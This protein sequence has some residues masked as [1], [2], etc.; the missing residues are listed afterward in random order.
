MAIDLNDYPNKIS[1]LGKIK[2]TG[3]WEHYELSKFYYRFKINGTSYKRIIDFSDKAWDKKTINKQLLSEMEKLKNDPNIYKKIS[4]NY[5]EPKYKST[6]TLNKVIDNY[7]KSKEKNTIDNKIIYDTTWTETKKRHYDNYIRKQIG[8]YK[9]SEIKVSMINECLE[10]QA[11]IGLKPR[12]IKTTLELLRPIFDEALED[13]AIQ[14]NPCNAKSIKTNKLVKRENTKKTV[15]NPL[16]T[17]QVF[18]MAI[19]ELYEDNPFYMSL[20]FFGLM[21]RRKSEILTLKW[22][23]ID[24]NNNTYICR[25]TKAGIDQTFTL[26]LFIKNELLKFKEVA[27]WVYPSPTNINNHIGNIEKQTQKVKD[28]VIEIYTNIIINSGITNKNHINIELEKK[29]KFTLHYFRNVGSSL[30]QQKGLESFISGAMGHTNMT[31]KNLYATID[32]K[33]SSKHF[34]DVIESNV[35]N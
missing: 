33:T 10:N 9:L 22:E 27:G 8:N 3:L 12:T 21:Q 25:D 29:P 2:V 7:F 32:Y 19:K 17:M 35:L 11:N 15:T 13:N 1:M 30:L 6:Y 5:K 24:F 20:Y 23:D 28:K 4:S 26:P 18:Y 16:E 34:I 31:T 14:S